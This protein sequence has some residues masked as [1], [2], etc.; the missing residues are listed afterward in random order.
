MI[1]ICVAS[2]LVAL[3]L[4]CLADPDDGEGAGGMAA[5]GG[6]DGMGGDP[7][8]GGRSGLREPLEHRAVANE[9]DRVRPPGVTLDGALLPCEQDED[10]TDGEN[11]RCV[12]HRNVECTY[13]ACFEDSTCAQ[14]DQRFACECEGGWASDHNICLHQGNCLVD[15]DC[16]EGG[17]CS[18][19]FGDCGTYSGTVGYFCHTAED[20]CVDNT[21]CGGP[22]DG[23][24][25][26]CKFNPAVGHWTCDNAQCVG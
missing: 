17:Y 14:G 6:A 11:G 1:R 13:D 8:L 15:A 26:Y 20:E 19:S 2:A 21:D 16:G 9:C 22:M 25:S 7:G 3:F 18:P 5:M 23:S 24:E 12:Q 4:G 10:C